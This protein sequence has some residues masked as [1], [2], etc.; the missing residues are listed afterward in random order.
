MFVRVSS[1]GQIVLPAE[2]RKRMRIETGDELVVVEWGG[3]VYLVPKP[4]DP[5]R[6]A[7]GIL[8]RLGSN[9]T[10]EQF[11]AERRAEEER[12]DRKLMGSPDE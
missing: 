1:K 8:R 5:I 7:R 9:L 6:H 2:V 11:R 10:V 12:R 4:T 3:G